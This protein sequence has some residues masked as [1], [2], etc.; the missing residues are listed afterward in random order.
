MDV[1]PTLVTAWIHHGSRGQ[2]KWLHLPHPCLHPGNGPPPRDDHPAVGLAVV[3]G[4]FRHGNA[5]RPT[6]WSAPGRH[7]TAATAQGANDRVGRVLADDVG[8]VDPESAGSRL[9]SGGCLVVVVVVLLSDGSF[10]VVIVSDGYL[11]VGNGG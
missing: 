2:F 9:L 7:G 1:H 11:L 3:L 4:H 8:R 5:R 10:V 6:G